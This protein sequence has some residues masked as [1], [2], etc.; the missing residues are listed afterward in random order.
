MGTIGIV[1]LMACAN[2]ATL[3]LVR[4]DARRQELAIRA[5]LGARWTRVA[6]ALLV[7]SLSLAL[8]G[9]ALGVG[10]A[11]AGLRALVTIG[12]AELP[13]L[14]EISIDTVVLGFALAVSLSSGLLFGVVPI[15]KYA[16]PQALSLDRGRRSDSLTRERQRWQ[17]GLVA[18]QMAL[19]LVV[20]VGS[21]LMIRSFQSLRR[22]DP[23]FARP[24]HVQTFSVAIPPV[25]VAE[26]DGVT[27]MQH[28]IVDRIAA[29]PGVASVAFT[30]RLPMDTSGRTSAALFAEGQ[31][32]EGGR[33]PSR[34]V[35]LISPGAFRTLGTPLI[36]GSEFTWIDLHDRR[37]VAIV[38]ENLAREMWGSPAAALGRRIGEGNGI[39]RTVVGVT[40]DIRDEGIHQ[41]ATPMLFL[42][43]RLQEKTLG[44]AAFL[45]RRVAFLV[46]S[47]RAGTESLLAELR[48]AVWSVNR[49]L[50][51]AEMRTL[52][53]VYGQSMA[54]TSFTLLLL[55]IAGAMALLLGL[56]GVYGVIAYAV[57]RQR[58]EIG[59]RLAL[60]A[61]THQI[62]R[63]FV[64]RALLVSG[65][66]IVLG[67]GGALW[68]TGFMRALLFGVGPLDPL[69]F[70]VVPPLL[71]ATAVL[72]SYLPARRAARVDP[73]I[74]LRHE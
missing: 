54:R 18:A 13:R 44:L 32:D 57:S 1:L 63:L 6:R 39:W 40:G 53:D 52:G 42:P 16:E 47:E 25:E 17:H 8:L 7:E 23:G 22:V 15:F 65:A 71:A 61:Q 19:A 35:R 14:T 56:T 66:G 11:Y 4:A 9:G 29:V 51:L 2:V 59:I 10:L 3:Q 20:L 69:T 5:A 50:P 31:P 45:P 62:R 34:Q 30:S 21:G 33:R 38:S 68:L 72:A 41:P 12:P 74:A 55:A 58:H 48:E 37:D 27:R 73:M 64:R 36:T 26:A 43:A 24:G 49:N 70:A 28:E 46:R 67:F 60:G